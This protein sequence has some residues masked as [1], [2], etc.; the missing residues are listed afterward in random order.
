[1]GKEKNSMV[2]DASA[3]LQYV[4]D[5]AGHWSVLLSLLLG[6]DKESALLFALL[7]GYYP[8][9]KSLL[10]PMRPRALQWACKLLIFNAAAVASYLLAVFVLGVPREAFS[11][12]GVSWEWLLLLLGNA[13][14]VVYEGGWRRPF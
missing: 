2:L 10:D 6:T 7:L 8:I 12:G 1:M 4:V 3:A 14:F 13:V 5:Y 9:L 11:I